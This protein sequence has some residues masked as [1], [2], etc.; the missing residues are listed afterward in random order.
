MFGSFL[1]FASRQLLVV[2]IF[3]TMQ[4]IKKHI[5]RSLSDIYSEDEIQIFT[6]LILET[7]TKLTKAQLLSNSDFILAEAQKNDIDKIIFRL[8]THEPIQYIL[9]E[10][11]FYGL[12]FKANP[13]VLIPRP[14]TEELIEW[15]LP[16]SGQKTPFSFGRGDGGEVRGFLDIGTG[17]GCIAVSLKK[18]FPF[19]QVSAM[20]ISAEALEV[21]RENAKMNN[22]E[23]NFIQADI[24][25]IKELD[26]KYDVIV[27]NPPYVLQR[28]KKNMQS[29]VLDFEPHIALF[30]NDDN[31]LIFYR[32]IAE[33]AKNHLNENGSL[34]FEIHAEQGENC[35][36]LLELIGF[37]NIMLRKDLSGNDRMI[38]AKIH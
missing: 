32:K 36:K 34:Y 31:P 30:V 37:E 1:F 15:I 28:D 16:D 25:E 6:F 23:I 26:Q 35:K 27:S 4:Q 9:G 8:K 3:I 38:C 10:T 29:N 18:K 33:L 5:Q 13:S 11:E 2:D 21:A 14:E 22:V 17:S 7:I 20:D 19:A 12:K 24:L